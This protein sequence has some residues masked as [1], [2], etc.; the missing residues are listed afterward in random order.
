M[1]EHM[2]SSGKPATLRLARECAAL[3]AA[4]V[5]LVACHSSGASPDAPQDAACWPIEDTT[6]GGAVELGTGDLQWIPA[7]SM[8]QLQMGFQKAGFLFINSRIQGLEPGDPS[9]FLNE[10]NPRTRFRGTLA[11][12]TVV[13]GDCPSR[14][15]YQSRSDGH[16]YWQN[17]QMLVFLP[18]EVEQKANNTNVLVTLE[19][20]DSAHHYAKD[21]KTIFVTPRPPAP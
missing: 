18:F 13:G 16:G 12:G 7:P 14:V 9:N 1:I 10:S 8:L 19:V 6:P 17:G 5:M 21:E 4:A 15:G 3:G 20:I 11:D 2:M